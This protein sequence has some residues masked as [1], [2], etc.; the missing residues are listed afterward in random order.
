MSPKLP[1]PRPIANDVMDVLRV[2]VDGHC[3]AEEGEIYDETAAYLELPPSVQHALDELSSK[4]L[5]ARTDPAVLQQAV[6]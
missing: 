1:L 4:L 2:M 5:E 6:G 3:G